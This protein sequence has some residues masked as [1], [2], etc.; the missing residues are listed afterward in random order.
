MKFH[1]DIAISLLQIALAVF[2]IFAGIAGVIN[3]DSTASE[4]TRALNSLFGTVQQEKTAFDVFTAVVELLVGGLLVIAPFIAFKGRSGFYTFIGVCILWA[5]ILAKKYFAEGFA[6]PDFIV[7]VNSVT[8]GIL[9][10]SALGVIAAQYRE[11]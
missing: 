4:F 3:Y 1:S 2:F 9:A 6:L 5:L 11:R 8:P 7:W 10:L